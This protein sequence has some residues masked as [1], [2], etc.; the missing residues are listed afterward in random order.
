MFKKG[1]GFYAEFNMRLFF[2]LLFKKCDA[3]CCIDPD[4]MLPVH[5]VS[6]LKNKKRIY[7]AHEYFS[8]MKEVISRPGVH[9]VWARV[10]KTFIPRFKNGYTVSQSIA[11]EFERLYKVKYETIRNVPVYK[12]YPE[13]GIKEKFIIYQGAVNEARGL[14]FLIPAMMQV[15]ARLFIYGDGNFAEQTKALIQQH[16]L[17]EKVI[18]KGMITPEELEDVTSQAYIG[19]NLVEHTGL[20]QYYSLANKF[21]DYI[22]HRIPQVTMNFPEYERVNNEYETAVLIGELNTDTVANAINSLLNDETLYKQLKDNCIPAAK[23]FNW[24]NEE[25]KLLNL[26][27]NIF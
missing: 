5:F 3:I 25:K 17:S 19:V 13:T 1:F 21:F 23:V 11:D 26:Y 9:Q 24:E 2:Y 18:M 7:D 16:G 6:A 12:D 10:E 15:N 27:K 14:E 8:Q 4:T 20:N 22:M